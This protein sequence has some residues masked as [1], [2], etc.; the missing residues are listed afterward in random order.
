[1]PQVPRNPGKKEEKEKEKEF[2]RT[3]GTMSC[4]ECRRYVYC[5]F[6]S[7]LTTYPNF[8]CRLKLKC[9]KVWQHLSLPIY[10]KSVVS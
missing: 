1:M 5:N 10:S 3:R 4:A 9:D 6:F 8:S 7:I 2:K